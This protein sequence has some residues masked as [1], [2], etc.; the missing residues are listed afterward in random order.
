[1][2]ET[3]RFERG[4]DVS[5]EGRCFL[6]LEGP[7][8]VSGIFVLEQGGEGARRDVALEVVGRVGAAARTGGGLDC[9]FEEVKRGRL[10][11]M[12]GWS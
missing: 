5:A 11:E 12:L 10:D 7:E 3:G 9:G 8:I 1:M 6:L 2:E 4:D